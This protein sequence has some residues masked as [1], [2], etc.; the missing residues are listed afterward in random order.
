MWFH[1]PSPRSPAGASIEDPEIITRYKEFARAD[2]ARR[3]AAGDYVS[4]MHALTVLAALGGH[5][6]MTVPLRLVA[7]SAA[8]KVAA[9]T[10]NLS[11]VC[12]Q[13]ALMQE[14]DFMAACKHRRGP[15]KWRAVVAAQGARAVGTIQ[16]TLGLDE[17]S[18][19][20]NGRAPNPVVLH[21]RSVGGYVGCVPLLPRDRPSLPSHPGNPHTAW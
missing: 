19:M 8:A 20:Y 3:L 14:P 17:R 10:M 15:K 12:R 18:M 1:F 2:F 5:L 7:A 13:L 4:A 9:A 16:D 21:V 6:Y 11:A